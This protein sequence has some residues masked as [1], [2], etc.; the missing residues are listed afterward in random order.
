MRPS[1]TSSGS[2]ESKLLFATRS[3]GGDEGVESPFTR[4]VNSTLRASLRELKGSGVCR[5][6]HRAQV[7]DQLNPQG[8]RDRGLDLSSLRAQ[9]QQ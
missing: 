1:N 5:G 2:R 9:A 6:E 8:P 7:R 4:S 3:V